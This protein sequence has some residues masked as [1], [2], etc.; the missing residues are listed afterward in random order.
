MEAEAPQVNTFAK[1]RIVKIIA[2][3]YAGYAGHIDEVDD[4]QRTPI[5]ACRD[6]SR[7]ESSPLLAVEPR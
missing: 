4:K 3:P 1:G 6:G 7:T 5:P 2:G